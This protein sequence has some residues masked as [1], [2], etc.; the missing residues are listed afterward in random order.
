MK[1]LHGLLHCLRQTPFVFQEHD[2]IIHGRDNTEG[3]RRG[4][5]GS[6]KLHYL[7]H[8]AVMRHDKQTTKLRIVYDASAKCDEFSLNECLYTGS[9][10]DQSILDILLRFRTQQVALTA[11]IDK[12]FLMVSMSVERPQCASFPWVDDIKNA[13]EISRAENLWI[14]KLQHRLVGDRNFEGWKM[15]WV[16]SLT[17][18]ASGGVVEGYLMLISPTRRNTQSCYLETTTSQCWSSRRPIKLSF[19]TV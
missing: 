14:K 19:I 10:F 13:Q 18:L 6:S 5:T 16:S 8:H 12:A 11:D 7:P 15:D 2:H 17:K 9:K 1:H 3:R 4:R